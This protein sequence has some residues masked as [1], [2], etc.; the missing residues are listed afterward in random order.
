LGWAVPIRRAGCRRHNVTKNAIWTRKAALPE[1]ANFARPSK[2]EAVELF[3]LSL[4]KTTIDF[5]N[6]KNVV[7]EIEGP[8]PRNVEYDA[9]DYYPPDVY[10]K[11]DPNWPK[12][13]KIDVGKMLREKVV[14]KIKSIFGDED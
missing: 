9:R 4:T 3:D 8:V 13:F 7:S 5:P 11:P 10:R 14:S 2:K 12:N 6:P 1:S